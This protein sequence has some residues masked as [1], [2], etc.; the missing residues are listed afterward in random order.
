MA[1]MGIQPDLECKIWRL[2][3]SRLGILVFGTRSGFGVNFSDSAHLWDLPTTQ[4]VSRG[5]QEP[6]HRSRLRQ[7]LTFFSRSWSRNQEW[8]FSIGIGTGGT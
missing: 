8:K 2:T 5:V 4:V 7:V 6:E 3:G 1:Q